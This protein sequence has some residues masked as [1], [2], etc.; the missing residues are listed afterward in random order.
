M[1]AKAI[2]TVDASKE[3]RVCYQGDETQVF[4]F[5]ENGVMHLFSEDMPCRLH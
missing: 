2:G 1:V 4:D 5:C 3:L